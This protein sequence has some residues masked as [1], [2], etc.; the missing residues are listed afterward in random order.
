[1]SDRMDSEWT[2]E[3]ERRKEARKIGEK[4]KKIWMSHRSERFSI[5]IIPSLKFECWHEP[6]RFSLTQSKGRTQR[7]RLA[8]IS[9]LARPTPVDSMGCRT[10]SRRSDQA[11]GSPN[12][13]D[14][15]HRTADNL[16]YP[17][18]WIKLA[19]PCGWREPIKNYSLVV[20]S[21]LVEY[22]VSRCKSVMCQK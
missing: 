2:D 20:T 19:I 22:L 6:G 1:M 12:S 17:S 21:P 4:E 13:I 16:E 18:L 8:V 7:C 9:F 10:N 5:S 11:F 14:D 15:Y 3:A